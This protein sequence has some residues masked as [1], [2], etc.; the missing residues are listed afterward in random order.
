MSEGDRQGVDYASR[1]RQL[2]QVAPPSVVIGAQSS[3]RDVN[4][5]GVMMS[6]HVVPRKLPN[7]RREH[8]S[9][10]PND[11]RYNVVCIC[12]SARGVAILV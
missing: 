2:G 1:I 11:R 4:D 6:L 10:R 9:R 3:G 8:A 12:P 7:R 5:V